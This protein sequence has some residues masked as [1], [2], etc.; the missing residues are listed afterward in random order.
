[1][2]GKFLLNEPGLIRDK[3]VLL[4]D[5]VITTGATLEACGAELSQGTNVRL[6]IA[7]LCYA[8]K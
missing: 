7:T 3:H 2:E 6:S 1:M 5:D 4:V 8:S